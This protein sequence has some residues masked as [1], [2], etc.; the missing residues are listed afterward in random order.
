MVISMVAISIVGVTGGGV[1]TSVSAVGVALAAGW[2]G[3]ATIVAAGATVKTGL[4]VAGA[5]TARRVAG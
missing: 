1:S 4:A 3:V 5:A 2:V